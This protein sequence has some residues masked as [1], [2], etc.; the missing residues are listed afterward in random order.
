MDLESFKIPHPPATPSI[1]RVTGWTPGSGFSEFNTKIINQRLRTKPVISKAK[2]SEPASTMRG[3]ILELT[4]TP[5]ATDLVTNP[6]NTQGRQGPVNRETQVENASLRSGITLTQIIGESLSFQPTEDTDDIGVVNQSGKVGN[7]PSDKH[8]PRL[9]TA[10]PSRI[11]SQLPSIC[12]S[13]VSLPQ[14]DHIAECSQPTTNDPG[15]RRSGWLKRAKKAGFGN[16]VHNRHMDQ[17]GIRHGDGLRYTAT[18]ADSLKSA[19][20]DGEVKVEGSHNERRRPTNADFKPGDD[21]ARLNKRSI[22]HLLGEDSVVLVSR[23]SHVVFQEDQL[24]KEI[25][26]PPRR[27]SRPYQTPLDL[28]SAAPAFHPPT[29]GP[30]ASQSQV[31]RASIRPEIRETPDKPLVAD[32][33]DDPS[34]INTCKHGYVLQNNGQPTH[35]LMRPSIFHRNHINQRYR[36][37][38]PASTQANP[39]AWRDAETEKENVDG[40]VGASVQARR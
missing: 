23:D 3:M 33:R 20:E 32:T 19:D 27:R 24:V 36:F 7:L 31:V 2:R 18:E 35:V 28:H 26:N 10:Q 29:F 25:S 34:H 4:T 5:L 30:L 14:S 9:V 13:D 12:H 21:V 16:P 40:A 37:E 6:Q 17:T 8:A 38:C 11:P 22:F 1:N 39:R 15:F